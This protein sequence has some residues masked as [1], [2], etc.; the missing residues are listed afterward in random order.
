MSTL[1]RTAFADRTRR[2]RVLEVQQIWMWP[3]SR[4]GA[5]VATV[6]IQRKVGGR[7]V[8]CRRLT[9]KIR[10]GMGAS[11][12]FN[13]KTKLTKR[14]EYRMRLSVLG[15]GWLLPNSTAWETLH[16]R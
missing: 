8:G 6:E 11:S 7:F 4:A 9:P 5:R 15:E 13:F 2:R 12:R 10:N 1:Q 16:V 14:G 3:R